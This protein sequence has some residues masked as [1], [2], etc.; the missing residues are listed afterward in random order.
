MDC[1]EEKN[2]KNC[3]CSYSGC[4]KKGKCCL[5]ITY[6]RRNNQLPACFFHDDYERTYDRSLD[7]F[8]RMVKESGMRTD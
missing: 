3:N 1:L 5:C 7:N 4:E 2:L 8:L 6:H